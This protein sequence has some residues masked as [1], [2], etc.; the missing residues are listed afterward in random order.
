MISPKNSLTEEQQAL[1]D[2]FYSAYPKKTAK[3]NA[4]NVWKKLNPDEELV[5]KMLSALE[6]QKKSVQWQRD[7]GRFIPYPA[8]WLNGKRWEDEYSGEPPKGE[9]S[10][11]DI[12]EIEQLMKQ[13]C[14][15]S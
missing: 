15:S 8:T 4:I 5:N 6:R 14:I 9:N 10:S 13:K 11:F 12:A 1:F 7:E 2:K 3:K